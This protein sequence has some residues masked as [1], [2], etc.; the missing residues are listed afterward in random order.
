[1]ETEM[2]E[3][4]KDEKE[5]RTMRWPFVSRRA[6]DL[7]AD[8]IRRMRKECA[9]DHTPTD[10]YELALETITE[11]KES[12]R[13]WADHA[14]RLERKDHGMTEVPREAR[15]TNNDPMPEALRDYITSFGDS[16][17]IKNNR[18]VAYQRHSGGESWEKI[19]ADVVVPPEPR[20]RIMGAEEPEEEEGEGYEDSDTG[21]P[22]SEEAEAGSRSG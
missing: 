18:A 3:T 1:M 10:A 6:Y 22:Q 2:E 20:E 12:N 9:A 11:L 17:T 8:Q 19:I 14:R 16:R 5:G 13:T 21:D 4:R 7:L 15:L